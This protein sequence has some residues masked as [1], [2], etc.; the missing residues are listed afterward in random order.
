MISTACG[1]PDFYFHTPDVNIY[2]YIRNA[3]G[4]LNFKERGHVYRVESVVLKPSITYGPKISDQV[5]E[6]VSARPFLFCDISL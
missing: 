4:L 1:N 6:L 3:N 5:R 2:R